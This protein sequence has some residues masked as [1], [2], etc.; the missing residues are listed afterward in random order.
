[1]TLSARLSWFLI[2]FAVW[3][4]YVWATFVWNVYPQHHFDGFFLVH[5]VIGAIT[6]LL[7]LGIG[8]IGLRALRA[9]RAS[10]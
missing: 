5:A 10:R 6:S 3:N 7:G 8:M 4:L 1:M 9:H 2:A